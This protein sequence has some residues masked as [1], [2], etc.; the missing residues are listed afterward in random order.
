MCRKSDAP[1]ARKRPF[2]ALPWLARLTHSEVHW[3]VCN[4]AERRR[5]SCRQESGCPPEGSR[6]WYNVA[7]RCAS[8]AQ[9]A[10]LNLS[11]WQCCPA[12][13]HDDDATTNEDCYG[14]RASETGLRRRLIANGLSVFEIDPRWNGSKGNA[15]SAPEDLVSLC[16]DDDHGRRAWVPHERRS[17]FLARGAAPQ[18][19]RLFRRR[20]LPRADGAAEAIRRGLAPGPPPPFRYRN[21]ITDRRL[22]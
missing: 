11:P 2:H 1:F 19:A 8:N 12:D 5:G 9:C 16:A 3:R 17:D 10:N 6:A 20:C 15:V 18:Y 22:C 13:A 7:A 14:R 21:D 4:R